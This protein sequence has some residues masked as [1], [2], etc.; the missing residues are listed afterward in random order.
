[1]FKSSGKLVSL[2]LVTFTAFNLAVSAGFA[3]EGDLTFQSGVRAFNSGEYQNA[4]NLFRNAEKE[5]S[6]DFRPLYYQAMCYTRLNQVSAARQLFGTL[7]NKFPDSE[8]AELA[9]KALAIAP[10]GSQP[11]AAT[12]LGKLGAIA[13]D[14]TPNKVSLPAEDL[15]G[16]PVVTVKVGGRDVKM[17]VRPEAKESSIGEK[18]ASD[19]KLSLV[20]TGPRTADDDGAYVLFDVAAGGIQR[21]MMP[22]YISRKDKSSA[23]LGG[24][25]LSFYKSDYDKDK[26]TLTLTAI[27]GA[28]D[29]FAAGMKLFNSGKYR[30]ALPLLRKAV[31]R[32]PQDPRALYCLAVGLQ[33]TGFMDEATQTYRAVRKRFGNTEAAFLAG[34]ALESLDPTFKRE[35]RTLEQ[36][37]K[38]GTGSYKMPKEDWFEVPYTIENS[39][40][41]VNAYIDSQ[42][43]ECYFEPNHPDCLLSLAQLRAIDSTYLN[44]DTPRTETSDGAADA[45][46]AIITTTWHIK[47]RSVR[48]GKVETRQVPASVVETRALR[49]FAGQYGT[50]PRPL[51]NG[52]IL[53]GMRWEIDTNRRVIKVWRNN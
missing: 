47:L 38:T 5:A 1:M 52:Y 51:I 31:A 22:V 28:S 9:R 21:R 29:P 27:P 30:D 7:I 6:Y 44:D 37:S 13:V 40:Y 33:K 43:V 45:N 14:T 17:V 20:T 24:D 8:G 15:D 48:F 50:F 32:R 2:A 11:V 42:N 35:M 10:K 41:K 36:A 3:Q 39:R 23:I 49:G 26:K 18:M 53:K 25:F 19:V 4:L 34:A 12:G 16:L 46:M